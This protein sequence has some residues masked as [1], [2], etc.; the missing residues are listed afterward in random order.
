MYRELTRDE[1][2]R[3]NRYF[4]KWGAFDYFK[5]KAFLIREDGGKELYL[6]NE[7]AKALALN[8]Q[9]VSVGIKLG[10]LKKHF[11]LS[12]EGA[13]TVAGT[14]DRKRV[15]INDKAEALALYGR[16]IFGNSILN[17]TKDF[18]DNEVVL[19]MN[20]YREVIAI[21]RTRVASEKVTRPGVTVTNIVD[22]GA[23]LREENLY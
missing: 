15:T 1:K 12:I 19:I 22:R 21:G 7:E 8:H 3:I 5:D 18:G 16:D 20:R 23:Y 13:S 9:P 6:M 10:D 17:H 2:T 11:W 14:S 4:G